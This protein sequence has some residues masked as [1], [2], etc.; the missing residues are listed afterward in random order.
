MLEL[1]K[2]FDLIVKEKIRILVIVASFTA[3]GIFY[4][5]LSPKVFFASTSLLPEP[6]SGG[7][8]NSSLLSQFSGI[9]GLGNLA[10]N[11]ADAI[12]PDLYPAIA[13]STPFLKSLVNHKFWH[14]DYND[15][16]TLLSYA[17]KYAPIDR[18]GLIKGYTIGLPGKILGALRA[19]ENL[20]PTWGEGNSDHLFFRPTVSEYLYLKSISEQISV[21]L[22]KKSG[23]ITIGI[24]STD[25]YVTA[26]LT[27]FTKN[28]LIHFITD[29]GL[30]KRKNTVEYLTNQKAILEIEFLE[31]QKRYAD[32]RER[33]LNLT[34][35]RFQSMEENIRGT[36]ELS[37]ELY[38]SISGQLEQAKVKL[39]EEV[40]VFLDIEPVIVPPIKAKPQTA[41][42]LVFSFVLGIL[43]A[44]LYVL[45]KERYV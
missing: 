19:T 37:K 5:V 32:F 24:Y 40:P 35:A 39:N 11:T 13:S 18:L 30:E 42:V 21:N 16:I 38:F 31:N 43:S 14:P 10:G 25:P 33:N 26:V 41:L 28:F 36:Y 6:K 45:V 29:Y 27:E 22:D 23:I 3:L 8:V 44:A 20:T 2:V 7:A 17:D 15:T 4:I 34:S 9:A 12:R 1:D